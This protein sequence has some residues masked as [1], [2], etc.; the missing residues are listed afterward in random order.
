MMS[1]IYLKITYSKSFCKFSFINEPIRYWK[2]MLWHQL[3][4]V[5]TRNIRAASTLTCVK[6]TL[7]RV[8]P[9]ITVARFASLG[10]SSQ[11]PVIWLLMKFAH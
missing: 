4:A 7:T 6:V 11:T 8:R 1:N 3:V 2:E 9:R 5:M 10:V